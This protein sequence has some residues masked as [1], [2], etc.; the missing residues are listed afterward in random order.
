MGLELAFQNQFTNW[1]GFWGGFGL[2]G[3]YTY[4]DS[5]A[6]YPDRE[7]TV[8][9]GPIRKRRQPRHWSTRSTASRPVCRTTTTARTLSRSGTSRTRTSGSTTTR[10]STSCS[11][12]RSR[13][14]GASSSSSINITDEPFTVYEGTVDRIR[15]QEYY[16]WWAT[17]GVRFDL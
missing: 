10:S 17:L 16:S 9:A 3:N 7:P 2:Y 4:V 11:G 15:Q 8:A 13:R 12:F 5:E 14:S 6:N 1:R